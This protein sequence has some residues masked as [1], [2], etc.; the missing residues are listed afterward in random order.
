VAPPETNTTVPERATDVFKGTDNVT[1]APL[2]P[3]NG[4]IPTHVGAEDTFHD[5]EFV[6]TC[7]VPLDTV[8][9]NDNED[10]D[11]TNDA[12]GTPTEIVYAPVDEVE[13]LK[14]RIAT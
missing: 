13:E 5:V 2:E 8:Y 11:N 1:V 7:T 3:I 14:F 4:E 10:L 12:A 9:G 6:V